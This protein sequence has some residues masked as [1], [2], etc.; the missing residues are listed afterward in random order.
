MVVEGRLVGDD[1]VGMEGDGTAEDIHVVG[2][3]RDNAGDDCGWVT[4]FDGVD[5]VGWGGCGMACWMRAMA[6]AAVSGV[7]WP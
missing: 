3:A 5:S 6:W 4:G 1:Q 2:E 7:D